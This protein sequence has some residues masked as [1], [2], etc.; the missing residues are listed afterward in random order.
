[1][2]KIFE[3]LHMLHIVYDI[4]YSLRL[5]ASN[6]G[7]VSGEYTLTYMQGESRRI[8][9]DVKN[10]ETVLQNIVDNAKSLLTTYSDES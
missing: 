4:R 8:F 10:L 3:D 5:F 6:D 9:L 7:K 2:E 1:M